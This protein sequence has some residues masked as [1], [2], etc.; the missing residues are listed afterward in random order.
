MKIKLLIAFLALSI[1]LFSQVNYPKASM[2]CAHIY[3]N[4]NQIKA[5]NPDLNKYDVNHYYLDISAS[6]N[7]T[8]ISGFTQITATAKSEISTFVVELN[9]EITV[10]S[11][12]I[13][14]QN[15]NFSHADHLVTVA[16]N[17]AIAT[18]EIFTAKIYYNR[19]SSIYSEG[20]YTLP[21]SGW[22]NV[23]HTL[24]EPYY[25]RNWFACKQDLNDKAD[26]VWVFVTVDENL[27]AGSNG[28]LTQVTDL[29][30][31]K[32][33]YEWKSKYPIA[34]YLISVAV[35]NYTE[36]N[37]YAKPE[38]LNGDSILIQNYLYNNYSGL[39]DQKEGM[40]VTADLINLFSEKYSL[41]PFWDEKYG[42]CYSPMY[43][44]AME[45]QTMTTTSSHSFY[46]IAHE[47][48]HQW[49]GDNV[50]C[51]TWQDIWINEGFASYSE[52][53]GFEFLFGQAD[54]TNWLLNAQNAARQAPTGSVY[55]PFE[56]LNNENRIF[57]W[58]LTY[59]KGLYL[60]HMIRNE[61]N[62]DALFFNT[63]NNFQTDFK[64]SVATGDDFRDYISE[65]T[66]IDFT[67]FFN[68]WYYGEG[69][70]T[71]HVNWWL[72]DGLL[73]MD[74]TQT[75]TA[76]NITPYFTNTLEIKITH[77]A[78]DTLLRVKPTAATNH[79]EFNFNHQVLAVAVNPDNKILTGNNTVNNQV[80][81]T[82]KQPLQIAIYPNPLQ[83]ELRIHATTNMNKIEILDATGKLCYFEDSP[84]KEITINTQD[85][86]SGIYFV[87]IYAGAAIY[88]KQ[89][90]KK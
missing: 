35:A 72:T 71:Y 54:A 57:S 37:I 7:S 65:Q 63:L 21:V 48:G 75:T 50:T 16:L 26:S 41:Y 8:A 79:F 78:G 33:R 76:T 60:V 14:G 19:S 20:I 52:Y 12:L 11:V 5:L 29:G 64:N 67:S 45:H 90:V 28:L 42:H 70:P 30:N 3:P 36:Y 86:N 47:L 73:K 23:M 85:L 49:F 44:G 89:I 51:A 58:N 39:Q 25:A 55:V 80:G 46:I 53:L 4:Q 40:N 1:V 62:D 13:N 10:D 38:A 17:Q 31:G 77:N 66:N 15:L 87:K 22:Q 68:E 81:I 18:A 83:N 84:S 9:S 61:I 69:Y 24:S 2:R 56:E 82:Q 43:A 6:N 74:V 32:K 27:K 34:Y 88:S 59:R